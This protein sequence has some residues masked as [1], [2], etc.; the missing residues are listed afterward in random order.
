MNNPNSTKPLEMVMLF[1]NAEYISQEYDMMEA[2]ERIRKMFVS[3]IEN[4]PDKADKYKSGLNVV[5][6]TRKDLQNGVY[7]PDTAF[8]VMKNLIDII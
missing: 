3:A 7:S 4:Q 8:L 6:N 1:H 2:L 5:E